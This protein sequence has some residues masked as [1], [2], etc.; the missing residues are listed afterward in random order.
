MKFII[1]VTFLGVLAVGCRKAERP[2]VRKLIR[3]IKIERLDREMFEM[4][5]LSLDFTAM[6]GKYGR[7]FDTYVGGVLNL[8]SVTNPDFKRLL[9]LFI[10]D[11]VMRE[12]ADTVAG[13]Y[14]DMHKQE[15]Q[16]AQAWAYYAYYFPDRIIPQVYAHISGFNQSIVVDSAAVGISLDN[17]LGENCIF[18]SMLAVPVPMYARK[19]MTSGDISRDV[20]SGWLNVEFPFQPRKNDLISGMIYQGKIIYILEKLFPDA[21]SAW[22]MGFT[23]EQEKWCED[24]KSQIWGY[25]I[26][27][28]YLFSTQQRL[29]MKY[30]NDAP[31]TS[32]MPV[33][34]PGKAVAWT[35]YQIVKKYVE[36]TEIVPEQLMAE[37]DYHK[38]LRIAGYRP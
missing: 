13:V 4:D 20:L 33:E 29:M 11:P 19:K 31:F 28:D 36:K 21:S 38:I 22:L 3:E 5:T 9:S 8:G 18:Y 1:V 17:Y 2:D 14:P 32:G 16:L 30:L 6:R 34:S 12:V 23:T 27:N 26:E 24:N 15:M 37:Q 35:G 7:Y 25:L 10:T